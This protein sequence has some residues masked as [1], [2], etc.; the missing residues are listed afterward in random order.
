MATKF[1]KI[2]IGNAKV[3]NEE[4]NILQ[5]SIPEE[6]IQENLA[7]FDGRKFLIFEVAQKK[8]PDKFGNTHNVYVNKIVE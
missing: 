3:K 5:V 1:E 2:Y 6:N 4:F 8:E 7:D